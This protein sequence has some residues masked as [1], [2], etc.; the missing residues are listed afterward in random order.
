MYDTPSSTGALIRS[1]GAGTS[2][3]VLGRNADGSWL[4]VRYEALGE[5]VW[6]GWVSNSGGWVTLPV[7]VTDLPVTG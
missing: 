3:T 2:L 5:G 4:N 6:I 1:L 7:P